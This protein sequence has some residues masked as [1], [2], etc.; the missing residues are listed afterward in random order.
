MRAG[1][2]GEIHRTGRSITSWSR[3]FQNSPWR[4]YV[5]NTERERR[6]P[7]WGSVWQLSIQDKNNDNGS[8]ATR[9]GSDH[10]RSTASMLLGNGSPG[11]PPSPSGPLGLPSSQTQELWWQMQTTNHEPKQKSDPKIKIHS[12]G[13]RNDNRTTE[14]E[15]KTLSALHEVCGLGAHFLRVGAPVPGHTEVPVG[16]LSR[17]CKPGACGRPAGPKTPGRVEGSPKQISTHY[18]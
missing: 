10:K 16:L 5:S 9:R 14:A 4:H 1:E 15:I 2:S 13:K 12:H 8:E 6:N 18:C 3:C 7:R 17:P 11:L